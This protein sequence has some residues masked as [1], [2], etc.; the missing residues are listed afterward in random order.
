MKSLALLCIFTLACVAPV[1]AALGEKHLEAEKKSAAE[2]GKAVVFFF[3]QGYYNPNC[4]KCILDVNTNNAA[5]TRALP[6]KY[7]NVITL[8]AGDNRGLDKLPQ[9]VKGAGGKNP[10]VLVATNAACDKVIATLHGRPDRKQADAFEKTVA[11]AT[12]VK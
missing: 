8:Y 3:T 6:R 11:A 7:A 12:T 4:P 2:K 10:P 5:M 1:T 9:C